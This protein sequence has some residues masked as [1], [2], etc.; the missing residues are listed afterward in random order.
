VHEKVENK[1]LKILL[2]C[3]DDL[4]KNL[5]NNT[6]SDRIVEGSMGMIKIE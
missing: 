4:A 1:V 5:P 2:K 6:R 3:N